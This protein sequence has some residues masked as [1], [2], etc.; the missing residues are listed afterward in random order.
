MRRNP[1]WAKVKGRDICPQRLLGRDSHSQGTQPVERWGIWPVSCSGPRVSFWVSG[2]GQEEPSAPRSRGW[3]QRLAPGPALA[4]SGRWERWRPCPAPGWHGV[5]QSFHG[6]SLS[7]CSRWWDHGRDE[8]VRNCRKS[9]EEAPAPALKV[10]HGERGRRGPPHGR[11]EP[12]RRPHQH[13]EGGCGSSGPHSG[14]HWRGPAGSTCRRRSGGWSHRRRCRSWQAA[15][16][17][18]RRQR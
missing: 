16:P 2:T 7:P 6:H 11:M 4:S 15:A 12:H 18:S 14:T 5:T 9:P 13:P 17:C 1:A 3:H 10:Q 8:K